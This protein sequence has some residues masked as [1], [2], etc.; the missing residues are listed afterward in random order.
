MQTGTYKDESKKN[1]IATGIEK[2][3]IEQLQLGCMQRMADATEAM[4]KSHTDLIRE[5]QY[6]KQ[7]KLELYKEV[8]SLK[9]SVAAYKGKYTRLKKSKL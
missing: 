9:R 3:T 1:W 8:E 5:N 2:P 4:A 6:L 7:Q